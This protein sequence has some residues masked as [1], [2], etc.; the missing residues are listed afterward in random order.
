MVLASHCRPEQ[1]MANG[2]RLSSLAKLSELRATVGAKQT[3]LEFIA[4]QLIGLPPLDDESMA[5]PVPSIPEASALQ[6]L[7]CRA[8]CCPA[9]ACVHRVYCRCVWSAAQ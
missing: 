8:C 6:L 1:G 7:P 2:F 3:L 9:A 4:D 5:T